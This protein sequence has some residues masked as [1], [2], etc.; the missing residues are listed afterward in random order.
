MGFEDRRRGD[1]QGHD[2]DALLSGQLVS[3]R[4]ERRDPYGRVG[5]LVGLGKY[6]PGRDIPELPLPLK[7]LR[8]PDLGNHGQRLFPHVPG[9]SGVDAH[10]RLFVGRGTPG[11]EVDSP[12]GKLVHH[13]HPLGYP[14]GVVVGQYHDAK[15]QA[16]ILGKP[17]Q[18]AEDHFRTRRG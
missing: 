6:L 11:A 15:T 17:A 5:L 3:G 12:M 16:D 7:S 9:E 13:R 10:A 18:R 14:Y 8:F 1:S 2:A 4:L